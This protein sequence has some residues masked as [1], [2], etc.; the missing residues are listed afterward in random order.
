MTP[1]RI[2]LADHHVPIRQGLK[3]IL[4]EK[5]DIEIVGETG[6]GIELL[7]LLSL[8]KLTPHMVILDLSLPNFQ[9]TEAIHKVK[10]THPE[11]KVLILSM[12]EDMEYLRQAIADGAEGYL[13]K[14]KTDTELLPAI[15]KIRRGGI[16]TP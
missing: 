12:H 10:A 2:I 15:E 7:N 11:V 4:D 5:S 8:N 6:E 13:M 3:R 9:G 14:E 16:Y 1:Y